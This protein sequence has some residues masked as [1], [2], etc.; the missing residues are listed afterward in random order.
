MTDTCRICFGTDAQETMIAPCNCRGSSAYIHQECYDRYVEHFPDGICRVCM[1]QMHLPDV[2]HPPGLAI[3]AL[4]LA[5]I[6]LNNAAVSNTMKF[7]LLLG[8]GGITHILNTR[9]LL[10]MRFVYIVAGMSMLLLSVQNDGRALI[11]VN[12]V[13]LLFA[14]VMT[15]GVYVGWEGVVACGIA[16]LCYLYTSFIALKLILEVDDIWTNIAFM[17]IAFMAWYGW[18]MMRQPLMPPV[19]H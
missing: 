16:T 14:T 2:V 7:V 13:L 8:F 4:V 19:P 18:Y 1:A 9:G 5:S 12:M 10:T 11:A 6:I 3:G 17:N 15:L